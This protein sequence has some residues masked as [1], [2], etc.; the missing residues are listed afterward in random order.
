MRLHAVPPLLALSLLGAG[1]ITPTWPADLAGPSTPR[2]QV[3][4]AD[5]GGQRSRPY[6]IGEPMDL[7][8]D[9]LGGVAELAGGRVRFLRTGYYRQTIVSWATTGMGSGGNRAEQSVIWIEAGQAA[10][11]K[12]NVMGAAGPVVYWT[13]RSRFT[14]EYLGAGIPPLDPNRKTR[15]GTVSRPLPGDP[16]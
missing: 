5:A 13:D 15:L 3:R 9:D 6:A 8:A 1:Y 14:W 11:V 7:V 12:A 10:S 2:V 4:P 16:A